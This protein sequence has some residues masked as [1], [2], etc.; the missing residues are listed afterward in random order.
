MYEMIPVKDENQIIFCL[1]LKNSNLT[2]SLS[3]SPLSL[4]LRNI[5]EEPFFNGGV[6]SL[7]LFTS[8]IVSMR[9][10]R[11]AKMKYIKEMNS[12]SSIRC[13]ANEST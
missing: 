7:I 6:E 5:F 1:N 3:R 8:S 13:V 2:I 10:L 11:R 4:K 9:R 12:M